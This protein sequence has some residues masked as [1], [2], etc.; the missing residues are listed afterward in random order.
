MT[1]VAATGNKHKI[2]EFQEIFSGYRADCQVISAASLN[3]HIEPEENGDSFQENALIKATAFYE[4]VVGSR[5]ILDRLS[6]S[7]LVVAD[8]SGLSVEALNGAPG[9]LS[10]RYA[11]IDGKNASD[12]ANMDKLLQEMASIPAGQRGA[13]FIC[14]VAGMGSGGEVLLAEG[15]L[16]GEIAFAPKGENGFGYDPILYLPAYDKTVAE[17]TAAEK[18]A[19]SHRGKALRA[20]AK[21]A[22]ERGL[23]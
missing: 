1:I 2:I 7:F 15:L 10:A 16:P 17:L 3:I 13:A 23:I 14:A 11:G 20:L 4:A 19:V 5:E 22:A 18:N 21:S 12:Q 9:V 6:G 8:D